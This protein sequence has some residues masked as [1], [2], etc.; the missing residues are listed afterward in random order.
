MQVQPINN[1]NTSF[2]QKRY[3]DKK[4]YG[5]LCDLLPK[6]NKQ[7][8]YVSNDTNYKA[9]FLK[10]LKV[11]DFTLTDG[12]MFLKQMP[13]NEQL[14]KQTLIDCGKSQLVIN[15]NDG[16]IID[17][18]K[19]I[20]TSWNKLLKKVSGYIKLIADNFENTALVKRTRLSSNGFTEEGQIKQTQL[21]DDFKK[22][23]AEILNY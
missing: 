2:G 1:S 21:N 11:D 22:L 14:Q 5:Y 8:V 10:E 15:N 6:M 20:C 9:S 12:R 19:P 16:E 17:Y 18:Y 3:L 7:T 23:E 13:E 4:T